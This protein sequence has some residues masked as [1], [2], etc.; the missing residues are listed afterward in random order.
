MIIY[1]VQPINVWI[2]LKTH[3][4]FD[5]DIRKS[6]LIY[7][8][9]KLDFKQALDAYM[10]LAKQYTLKTSKPIK[11]PVWAWVKYNDQ[12]DLFKA[13]I[14]KYYDN[15]AMLKLDVPKD[16]LLLSDFDLWNLC[17][18]YCYIGKDEQDMD[19]FYSH[20]DRLD[21]NAYDDAVMQS[22]QKIF[23]TQNS[24]SVQAILPHLELKD[25][26]AVQIRRQNHKAK[27]IEL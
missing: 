3:Q 12:T 11:V 6:H 18:D 14:P 20:C 19:A 4:H 27:I 26:Q 16:K 5:A 8:R 15:Q 9:S 25:V 24:Q 10:W 17:L 23:D 21:K 1:T 7:N 13:N 2:H 22:W